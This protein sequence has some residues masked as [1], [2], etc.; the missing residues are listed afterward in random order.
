LSNICLL[1][2]KTYPF[3]FP[4]LWFV[5]DCHNSF[6]TVYSCIDPADIVKCIFQG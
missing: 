5:T 1:V 4:L 3:L 6:L 2:I